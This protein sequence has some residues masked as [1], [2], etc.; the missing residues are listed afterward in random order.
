MFNLGAAYYNGDGVDIRDAISYA[1]FT[2]AKDGGNK[3]ALDAVT[4]MDAELTADKINAGL[5]TIAEMYAEGGEVKQ[6][7]SESLRWY[8]K[9]AE[10]GDADSQVKL[11]SM[12][13]EGHGVAKD[14]A[15]GRKWCEAAAAQK[16]AAGEACL[17]YLYRDGLGVGKNSSDAIK[18]LTLAAQGNNPVA[19]RTLGQVYESGEAGK[20]DKVEALMWYL[21]AAIGGDKPS[22][23]A[24]AKI[25]AT[26]TSSE[27]NK[28]QKRMR[29]SRIDP[30]KVDAFLQAGKS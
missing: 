5:R 21:R 20:A 24:A 16:S 10:H 3:N 22:R 15:E 6:S 23:E 18:H 26:M 25:K 13:I 19:A 30:Q 29:E 1:W 12:L 4:R 27:W 11:A 8:R 2:L 17:G 9:A 14:Y 28:A 7:D